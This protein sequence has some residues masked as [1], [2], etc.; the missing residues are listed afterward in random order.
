MWFFSN[1]KFS[2]ILKSRTLCLGKEIEAQ[3]Q[4]INKVAKCTS[5]Y[6][7][8]SFRACRTFKCESFNIYSNTCISAPALILCRISTLTLVWFVKSLDFICSISNFKSACWP[9]T[10]EYIY[11]CVHG[12][13]Y[14]MEHVFPLQRIYMHSFCRTPMY[15]FFSLQTVQ[16]HYCFDYQHVFFL[17]LRMDYRLRSC[18]RLTL[19][20]PN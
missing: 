17:L 14:Q 6:E 4:Q 9:L 11:I 1:F 16:I 12:H 7:I 8:Q 5:W 13:K 2:V 19:Y 3:K 10:G 20:T 15:F 18:K